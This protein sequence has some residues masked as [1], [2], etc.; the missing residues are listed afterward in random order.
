MININVCLCV[1]YNAMAVNDKCR[2][3]NTIQYNILIIILVITI[4]LMSINT[5]TYTILFYKLYKWYT[6]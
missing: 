5:I 6:I 4:I 2:N 3:I 1:Y